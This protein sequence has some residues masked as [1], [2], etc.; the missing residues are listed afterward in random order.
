LGLVLCFDAS[1]RSWRA[2]YISHNYRHNM[3]LCR[4]FPCILPGE[5]VL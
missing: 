5:G 1:L 3:T 4:F 2:G